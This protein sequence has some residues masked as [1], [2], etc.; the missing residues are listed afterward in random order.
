MIGAYVGLGAKN[1]SLYL[2][3]A[4]DSSNRNY[5]TPFS[6]AFKRAGKRLDMGEMLSPLQGAR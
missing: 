3:G 6:G 4:Y 5:T 1:N 2:M